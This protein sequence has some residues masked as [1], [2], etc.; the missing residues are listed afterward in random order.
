MGTIRGEKVGIESTREATFALWGLLMGV[1]VWYHHGQ[2]TAMHSR[3]THK[4]YSQKF[5]HTRYDFQI[6][7]E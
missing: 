6:L 4:S 5:W 2:I 7:G 1:Y 3:K